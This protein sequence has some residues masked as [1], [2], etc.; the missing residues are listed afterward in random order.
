VGEVRVWDTADGREMLELP[1]EGFVAFS[2]DGTRLAAPAR[3]AVLAT[4]PSHSVRVWDVGSSPLTATLR[5]DGTPVFAVTSDPTGRL[6][7]SSA[8]SGVIT[9]WDRLTRKPVRVLTGHKGPVS[10]L[11][12]SPDGTR[13]ASGSGDTTARL[14]DVATGQCIRTFEGHTG[15]IARVKFTSSGTRL[16]T[17]SHDRTA[18]VWQIVSGIQLLQITHPEKVIDL[19]LSPDGERVAICGGLVVRVTNAATGEEVKTLTVPSPGL[20]I[21]LC[22]DVLAV[23]SS[24]GVIR[25]WDARSWENRGPFTGHTGPVW[26][27]AIREQLI[28]S[29]GADRTVRVWNHETRTPTAV[30]TGHLD[31]VRTVVAKEGWLATASSD[32]TVRLW[33]APGLQP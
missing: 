5:T 32:G 33:D 25:V 24:D 31:L 28:A 7:A 14:W 13:L 29:T 15:W 21:A 19:A 22:S 2:P 4:S 6:L 26:G 12:F 10:G 11:A 3:G 9:I 17:G 27:V 16:I 18:R 1:G 8:S 20:S 30:F 23:G